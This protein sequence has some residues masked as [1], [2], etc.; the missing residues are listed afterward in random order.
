M[1][2]TPL[3]TGK[4]PS[5]VPDGEPL[6]ISRLICVI[7]LSRSMLKHATYPQGAIVGAVSANIR[8]PILADTFSFFCRLTQTRNVGDGEI[9]WVC[10]GVTR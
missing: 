3:A 10:V 2:D 1:S 4:E 9:S 7:L 8:G 6:T 5:A